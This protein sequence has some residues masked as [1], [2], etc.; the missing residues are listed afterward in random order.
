MANPKTQSLNDKAKRLREIRDT[1]K[2]SNV[3]IDDLVPLV[4][5]AID[6]YNFLQE[7]LDNTLKAL[8]EKEK[9]IKSDAQ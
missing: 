7:R 4:D 3:D 6:K 5:E 1:F 8:E 9:N 2:N